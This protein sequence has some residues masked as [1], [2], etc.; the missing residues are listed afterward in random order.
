MCWPKS[1][2]ISPFLLTAASYVAE[3]TVSLKIGRK[4]YLLWR[5][6]YVTWPDQDFFLSKVV[7]RM[8]H[9]LCKISARSA[10][11]LGSHSRKTHGGASSHSLHG[12][13]LRFGCLLC[14]CPNSAVSPELWRLGFKE[15][16]EGSPDRVRYLLKM[17]TI[18][19]LPALPSN[20]PFRPLHWKGPHEV[21][22]GHLRPEIGPC[23]PGMDLLR[24]LNCL[25]LLNVESERL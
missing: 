20:G 7:Q 18:S 23:G 24:H 8:P 5:H 22:T 11:R 10:Q 2:T 15:V 21:G 3:N 17:K 12:R 6:S 1:C 9:K 19:F 14:A 25:F 4:L 16:M 13:G